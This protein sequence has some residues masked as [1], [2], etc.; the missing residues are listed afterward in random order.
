[1][2][3]RN[4][5]G[6]GTTMRQVFLCN[7]AITEQKDAICH[8]AVRG[9]MACACACIHAARALSTLLPFLPQLSWTLLK[10]RLAR[11]VQRS[12][13]KF[14]TRPFARGLQ[15]RRPANAP[16]CSSTCSGA[17]GPG[18][19]VAGAVGEKKPPRLSK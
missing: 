6:Q 1:M 9:F 19:N 13:V 14:S 18:F 11:V 7:G 16:I 12:G 15:N 10:F 5:V 17:V 8:L 2:P 4:E 3:G